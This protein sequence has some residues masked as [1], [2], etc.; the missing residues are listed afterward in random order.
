[1]ETFVVKEVVTV[2]LHVACYPERQALWSH[3]KCSKKL[4]KMMDFLKNT[5]CE[6]FSGHSTGAE[7]F[8][9]LLAAWYIPENRCPSLCSYIN[10]KLQWIVESTDLWFQWSS[11]SLD[12]RALVSTIAAAAYT[13]FQKQVGYEKH[14]KYTSVIV[15]HILMAM[16]L[17]CHMNWARA[18]ISIC[19][20]MVCCGI[21][22]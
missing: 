8:G 17:T 9:C 12:R 19:N 13:F 5:F 14:A 11:I 16:S 3:L 2:E 4:G 6:L 10:T 22:D 18:T 1:M 7:R 21:W 20:S 15:C